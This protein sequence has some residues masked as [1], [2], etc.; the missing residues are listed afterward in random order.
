MKQASV[1]FSI[2]IILVVG[3]LSQISTDL[4]T[5]SLP[6][7]ARGLNVDV[8]LAQM[9]VSLFILSQAFTHLFY[10]P[11]SEGVGRRI[12]LLFG[13]AIAGVGSLLCLF[14]KNID[15]LLLGR[16]IQGAGAGA[17]TALFRSIARDRFSGEQLS[18]A[19]A[20][21]SNFV[22][23]SIVAAPFVGGI[24][25]QFLDWRAVFFILTLYTVFTWCVVKF[26][27]KETSQHHHKDRLK[28]G[29]ILHT[30]RSL[31]GNRHFIAYSLCVF[32]TSGGMISWI[33]SGPVVLIKLVGI[34]PAE[35]GTLTVFIG[36][37]MLLAN[38]I[39][40]RI[41]K[42]I[43][44]KNTIYIGLS[45]MLFS[46][47][48]MMGLKFIFPIGILVVFIPALVFVFGATFI[49]PNTFALA[50]GPLGE[51]AGYAGS[52][53]GFIQV[54][55]GAVFGMVVSHISEQSQLPVA[56]MFVVSAVGGL[57]VI[58]LMT[59]KPA[60]YQD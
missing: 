48:L 17:C 20:I 3:V 7:I 50:F 34:T 38:F 39:N 8:N 46:G 47:L 30:Y 57:L 35:F 13:I 6:A 19:M 21:A 53:Y 15:I 1:G 56:W 10:G 24:I 42:K 18:G 49:W 44:M 41:I 45:I 22:V 55:G 4:Y 43:G 25:Q 11:L 16:V 40:V 9:S 37:M 60:I 59:S 26:L 33:V 28:L 2:F 32:L 58:R 23:L 52:V 12:T 29:F 5:P 36:M 27:Y 54:L 14:A 51:I 31:F